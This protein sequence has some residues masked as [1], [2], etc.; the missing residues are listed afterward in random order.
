MEKIESFQYNEALAITS[1]IKGSSKEKL[2]QELGFGS[3]KERQWMRKLCYLY[4][5]MSS[6]RPSYLCDILP[7]YKDLSKTKVFFN[8]CCV[9][10]KTSKTLFYHIQ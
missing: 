1:A 3:L 4:K 8:H 7:H 9:E 6:K 2:Y 10:Q 5:I